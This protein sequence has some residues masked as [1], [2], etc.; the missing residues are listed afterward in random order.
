MTTETNLGFDLFEIYGLR[1]LTPKAQIAELQTLL[2]KGEICPTTATSFLRVINFDLQLEYLL[3]AER[4]I[5][6]TVE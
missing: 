5:A 4:Y 1:G 3:T 2:E 6:L